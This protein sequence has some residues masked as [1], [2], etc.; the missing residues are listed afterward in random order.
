MCF[1]IGSKLL[2]EKPTFQIGPLASTL[3]RANIFNHKKLF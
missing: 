3:W 2:I 1:H